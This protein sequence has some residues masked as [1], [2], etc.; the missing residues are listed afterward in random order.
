MKPDIERC[1]AFLLS[2][3]SPDKPLGCPVWTAHLGHSHMNPHLPPDG[4][5]CLRLDK[6]GDAW[7]EVLVVPHASR[8]H[9]TGIHG[10]PGREAL[11]IRL[12]A[13]PVDGKANQALI[14]W[15][16]GCLGIAP[17]AITLSRGETSRQ[18]Q[19][20]LSAAAAAV[21]RWDKLVAEITG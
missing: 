12:K 18:K 17:N 2:S 11:R 8:T 5:P 16:A 10:A 6:H 4:L 19:L 9:A 13:V 1:R 7:L 21:A 15:L 3:S 14:K 20:H